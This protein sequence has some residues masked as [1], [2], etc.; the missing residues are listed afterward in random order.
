M[1]FSKII[2]DQL[3]IRQE[4]SNCLITYKKRQ[5]DISFPKTNSAFVNKFIC[6]CTPKQ[7]DGFPNEDG[8]VVFHYSGNLYSVA[9]WEK[10]GKDPFSSI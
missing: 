3:I 2:T 7:L 10:S 4:C 9:W 8:V 5:N 1:I 6:N